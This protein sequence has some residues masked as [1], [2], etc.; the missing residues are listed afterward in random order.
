MISIREQLLLASAQLAARAS[1]SRP[2]DDVLL[3]EELVSRSR[4][5]I[6]RDK[7]SHVALAVV[8]SPSTPSVSALRLD[9]LSAEFGVDCTL[10]MPN[11]EELLRVSVIR[12]HS[13]DP[14]IVDLFITFCTAV[15]EALSKGSTD[16]DVSREVNQ[17]ISL[18]HRLVAPA[19]TDVIGLIGELT[20]IDV[21]V[22]TTAWVRAWH[23]DP[24][25]NIDFGFPSPRVE[26]EVKATSRQERIHEVS[27]TQVH[28]GPP[29]GRFF[30][31]VRVELRESG[32]SL[33]KFA[34][35]I[36]DKLAD[37]DVVRH[38]WKVLGE[39]CGS[40]FQSFMDQ[41]FIAEVSQKSILFF[42]SE[43]IPRPDL[44]LPLPSGVS[45]IR[46]RSDFALGTPLSTSP[47]LTTVEQD[48][49]AVGSRG[50]E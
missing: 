23:S 18:F 29:E 3:V 50:Q 40:S 37:Q 21:A 32:I 12:C 47:P 42:P 38:F 28:G 19:R 13:D 43:G 49:E 6:A 46:F 20:A 22:D 39:T 26:V 35:T 1:H 48:G 30:A 41:R 7:S 8:T 31:S 25:D 4:V 45:G 9:L 17:W 16:L 44:T 15:I 27:W 11:T 36:A 14:A 34:R 10:A 24:S 5:F 2:A 33:G